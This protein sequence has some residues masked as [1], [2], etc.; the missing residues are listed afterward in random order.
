MWAT[1]AVGM[2]MLGCGEIIEIPVAMTSETGE[3]EDGATSMEV[4]GDSTGAD[5]TASSTQPPDIDDASTSGATD[6]GSSSS[7]GRPLQAIPFCMEPGQVVEIPDD[8]SVVQGTVEVEAPAGKNVVALQ[9][10]L[11]V[12]HSRVSDL[13]V[14]LH[15]PD[16]ADVTLLDNPVCGGANIDATFEDHARLVGNEQCL[17]GIAAIMGSVRAM[18]PID[19]L[20]GPSMDGTWTLELSDTE[21]EEAGT[22][23]QV[24]VVLVVEGD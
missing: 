13:D 5:S 23:D 24:C 8:G 2:A 15:A 19:A 6:E 16:D 3:S 11:R 17:A 18:D 1:L 10:G 4:T 9:V 14:V 20:L 7:G 12:S 22:L 21:A